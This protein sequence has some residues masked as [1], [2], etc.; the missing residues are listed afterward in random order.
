MCPYTYFNILTIEDIDRFYNIMAQLMMRSNRIGE[1][2]T[3]LNLDKGKT[4]E[5]R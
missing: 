2:N 4:G 1:R 5:S 3:L